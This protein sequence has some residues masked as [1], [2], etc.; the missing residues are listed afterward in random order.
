[1]RKEKKGKNMNSYYYLVMTQKD[2]LENQGI[3]EIL[4]ER[5]THYSMKKRPRDFWVLVSPKFIYSPLIL[6]QIE[7]SNFYSQKKNLLSSSLLKNLDFYAA[8]VSLDKD[9]I[10]WMQVRLGAFEI[11]GDNQQE[12][13]KNSKFD[14]VRGEFSQTSLIQNPLSSS[15]N[16]I[17]PDIL[18][19][20]NQDFLKLYYKSLTKELVI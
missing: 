16:C 19:N 2:L 8:L 15:L 7:N 17:H 18:I 3:E 20:R 14:G 9:F 6:K 12:K 4:R 13:T 11:L 1:M 10:N 5:A